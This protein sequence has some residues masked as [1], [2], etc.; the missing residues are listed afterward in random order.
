MTRAVRPAA[1]AAAT[2]ATPGAPRAFPVEVEHGTVTATEYPARAA[3]RPVATLILAHGAGAGQQ[4]PFVTRFAAGFAARGLTVVTF[5]FPYTEAHRRMPDRPAALEACVRA[6]VAAVADRA[7]T[8][9]RLF[10]G[11]K[12]MGGRIVSQVAAAD[13][14]S[15]P[16][17]GL[18]FLGYPLHPPGRPAT[19]RD[20]HLPAITVPMLFTQGSRDPFG[21]PAEIDAVCRRLGPRATPHIVDGGDHSFV[22]PRRWRLT[23]DAVEASVQ[24]VVVDWIGRVVKRRARRS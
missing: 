18:V 12:S 17:A 24:E 6:V 19:L 5:N 22:V 2:R 11:G 1:S 4:S 7:G 15:S 10:A 23:Q 16:L 13:G 3:H 14:R 8:G 20:A 21:T 9:A